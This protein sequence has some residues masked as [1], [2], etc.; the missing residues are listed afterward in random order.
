[1][2]TKVKRSVLEVILDKLRYA[3]QDGYS[4][5]EAFQLRIHVLADVLVESEIPD[6]MQELVLDCVMNDVEPK[7][8]R[9]TDTHK[10]VMR[11]LTVLQQ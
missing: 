4:C 5:H 2:S 1:M 11:L 8:W 10:I 9:E 6:E 3:A 7:V